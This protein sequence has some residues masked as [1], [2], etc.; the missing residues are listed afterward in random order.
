M[1]DP[2]GPLAPV[3]D[4]MAR[5]PG[6]KALYRRWRETLLAAA[7]ERGLR[8]RVLVDLACG[9]GNSTVPWSRRRGWT[10]VG[11]DRSAAM[12]RVARA[13]SKA[14]RW[15]R[16]DLVTLNLGLQADFATCHFDALN[17][18][19]DAADL[20]RVFARVGATLRPGGLFQF[21]LNTAHWLR[22]LAGRDKLFKVGPHWFTASNSYD[23]KT[24]VATFNQLWF[25][26]RGRLFE[27][28]LVT[29]RER[30]FSDAAIRRMLTSGGMR[31]VRVDTQVEIDGRPMRKL[32][33][34]EKRR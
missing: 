7:R 33:L 3:Y 16:Q 34:A 31:L 20:E 2:Y 24:G 17:H 21:D 22:W 10:V 11:V 18:V 9:T 27:R 29:V 19:L 5:D 1:P 26:R 32:Y 28:R 12:L 15:V 23:G 8:G 6:I 30:A 4:G 14:V 25:V 13:K